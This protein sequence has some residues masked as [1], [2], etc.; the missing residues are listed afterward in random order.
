MNALL[1]A[2][3]QA[4]LN[5]ME[6]AFAQAWADA[7]AQIIN[8]ADAA[9][10]EDAI[11]AGMY[12][13]AADLIVQSG[14]PLSALQGP[15]LQSYWAGGGLVA[16]MVPGVTNPFTGQSVVLGFN[17]FHPRAIA[18]AQATSAQLVTA[19]LDD[20]RS[21]I[22]AFITT[23]VEQGQGP[24]SIALD[25]VGRLNRATGKRE[26]GIIGLTSQQMQWVQNAR[27][28]LSDPA[29]ATKFIDRLARDKRFDAM[30]KKAA[31]DGKA[32]ASAD[33]DKIVQ[34]YSSRLLKLRGE[35]IARTESLNA[36]RAGRHETWQ[37]AID[38]GQMQA[39]DVIV[40][41]SATM[42]GRTRDSHRH[43]NRQK[44]TFGNVFVSEL[45]SRMEFPGDTSHGAAAEDT[46]QCRCVALYRRRRVT[47]GNL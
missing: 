43:L 17:G 13:R 30:I 46:I 34:D 11:R 2:D 3:I 27:A 35:T 42:D 28:E 26:G 37:Q 25:I 47:D 16:G 19:I 7:I 5:Q 41:W 45:G 24:R 8:Q 32:L 44:V 40:E 10:V 22:Q 31:K 12:Q 20:Q 33:V 38:K 36:L 1:P 23:A 21:G 4:V 9:A 39:S 15:V 29:T 6:P 18:W 14:V